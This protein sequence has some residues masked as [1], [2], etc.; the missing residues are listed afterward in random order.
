MTLN[1]R[2]LQLESRKPFC[3]L[4]LPAAEERLEALVSEL[5]ARE[6]VSVERDVKGIKRKID[7]KAGVSEIVVGNAEDYATLQA[8]GI[9]G[10][11]VCMKVRS[12]L[13]ASGSVRIREVVEALLRKDFPHIAVRASP[14]AKGTT[15]LNLEVHRRKPQGK[16]KKSASSEGSSASAEATEG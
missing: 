13:K 2:H 4:T 16:P 1:H 5:N 8:T 14:L 6:E 12:P 9:V 15:P 11:L 10:D 7:V 3:R